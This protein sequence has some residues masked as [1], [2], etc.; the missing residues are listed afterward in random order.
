[1]YVVIM[2]MF[3]DLLGAVSEAAIGELRRA[4]DILHD[5]GFVHGDLRRPNVLI[6]NDQVKL[7]D[8]DWSGKEGEVKY[9]ETMSM[10]HGWHP[11]VRRCGPI[12]KVH[13]EYMHAKIREKVL[14]ER[15]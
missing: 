6:Q 10:E 15:R 7:I 1:M 8:F 12:E 3:W 9:P 13:D 11:D 2:D 5:N 4:I 14:T